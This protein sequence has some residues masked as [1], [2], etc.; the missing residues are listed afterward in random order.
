MAAS[1]G[2]LGARAGHTAPQPPPPS[3]CAQWEPDAGLAGAA[4]PIGSNQRHAECVPLSPGDGRAG[5][6]RQQ[7]GGRAL[8]PDTVHLSSA[9]RT[10]HTSEPPP[11]RLTTD[12]QT[13]TAQLAARRTPA[14]ADGAALSE[15]APPPPP[16][17]SGL[18][19]GRGGVSGAHLEGEQTPP[20]T[21]TAHTRPPRNKPPPGNHSRN[22]PQLSG[23]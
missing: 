11:R 8:T 6:F 21:R 15:E 17:L 22:P 13:D 16:P 9:V 5:A 18:L 1:H 20:L 3:H 7:G 12:R 23:R 4:P 19:G 10:R 2:A 14:P